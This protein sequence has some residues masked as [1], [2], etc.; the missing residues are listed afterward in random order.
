MPAGCLQSEG[1]ADHIRL[2]A[3]PGPNLT[4]IEHISLARAPKAREMPGE[5]LWKARFKHF[6][7]YLNNLWQ[8]CL[9]STVPR[10]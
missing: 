1:H 4:W 5:E 3:D 9:F 8:T 6:G 10:I 2:H 7:E